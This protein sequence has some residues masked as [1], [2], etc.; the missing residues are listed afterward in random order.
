MNKC[1]SI[2]DK[3]NGKHREEKRDYYLIQEMG[4]FSIEDQ[5]F[6]S[7]GTGMGRE[8]EGGGGMG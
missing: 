5:N 1:I 4:K 2:C 6:H 3:L 7:D 8:W